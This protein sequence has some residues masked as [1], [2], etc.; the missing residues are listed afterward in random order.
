MAHFAHQGVG[1]VG[2]AAALKVVGTLGCEKQDTQISER[3]VVAWAVAQ[4]VDIAVE[5]SH[6][7][8]DR[9]VAIERLCEADQIA[10]R[11]V[12]P[13]QIVQRKFIGGNEHRQRVS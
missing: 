12:R 2:P 6:I 3:K 1:A 8:A 4:R 10:I 7:T 5:I 11:T 13:R 9:G